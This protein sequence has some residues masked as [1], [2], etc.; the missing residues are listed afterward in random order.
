[1]H[2]QQINPTED[3]GRWYHSNYLPHFD[4]GET[5]QFVTYRLAGSL[6]AKVLN[7][8]KQQHEAGLISDIEYHGIIDRY[9]DAAKGPLHLRVPEIAAMVQENLLHFDGV[10]YKLHA[11]VI[12]PNHVHVLFTPLFGFL[13]EQILHSLRSFTANEANRVLGRSGAFW[14]RDYYDRYIR[15]AEH[16]RNTVSYIDNNPVKTRLCREQKDWPFGSARMRIEA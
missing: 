6:P 2:D 8:H 9:L 15:S 11:W 7:Y 16:F 1:M 12:M 10:K 3:Q 4:A 5:P 13:L 14:S